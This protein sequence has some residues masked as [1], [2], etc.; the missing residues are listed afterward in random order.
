LYFISI[1]K[2]T[3]HAWL[4]NPSQK[5]DGLHT[6]VITKKSKILRTT[7]T[8]KKHDNYSKYTRKNFIQ[9]TKS[10]HLQIHQSLIIFNVGNNWF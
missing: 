2:L 4:S 6:H 5:K 10:Q 3:G 9:S 8:R 1:K 7:T